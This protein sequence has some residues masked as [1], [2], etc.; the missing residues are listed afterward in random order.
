[1]SG[2]GACA[3]GCHSNPSLLRD[4]TF[5][6]GGR[7]LQSH[8]ELLE[9]ERPSVWSFSPEHHHQKIF[10]YVYDILKPLSVSTGSHG[11]AR[12]DFSKSPS[13]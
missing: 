11:G 6:R 8:M 9:S 12:E 13:D 7:D 2:G 10:S 4:W 5:L 3:G 1:M